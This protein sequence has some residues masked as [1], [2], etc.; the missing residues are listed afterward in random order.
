LP[1]QTPPAPARIVNQ[2]PFERALP[3]VATT[4]AHNEIL[5]ADTAWLHA[6]TR[7]MVAD[8]D[9]A[10]DVAQ[11]TLL[12]ACRQRLAIRHLRPWLASVAANFARRFARGERRRRRHEQAVPPREP[13]PPTDEV[14]ARAGMHRDVV[15]AVLRLGEPYRATLL[16]RFQEQQSCEQIA[17]RMRVPVET[18]R[19]RVK[20]GL[21]LLR[22]AMDAR[23]GDRRAWALPI[24][25]RA[26]FDLAA[27]GSAPAA[28]GALALL[29]TAAAAAGL[30]A[31]SAWPPPPAV[32]PPARATAAGLPELASPADAVGP[33]A[34]GS[35]AE[36][37]AVTTPFTD[38]FTHV[39]AIADERDHCVARGRVVDAA[40]R[41]PLAGVRVGLGTSPV[42]TTPA[43]GEPEPPAPAATVT[44]ADGA[45]ELDVGNAWPTEIALRCAA[46]A[47]LRVPLGFQVAQGILLTRRD[48]EHPGRQVC[49]LGEIPL[50]LGL[51][52][53]GRV[54]TT[55][56]DRPVPGAAIEIVR[57]EERTLLRVEA[58]GESDGSG[59]FAVPPQLAP[60]ALATVLVARA[61]SEVGWRELEP[62]ALTK[63]QPIEVRLAAR[64][65]L[66]VHIVDEL[67]QPL[68]SAHVYLCP[69]S[70][71]LGTPDVAIVARGQDV[72]PVNAERPWAVSDADGEALFASL[73]V[74]AGVNCRGSLQTGGAY[75]LTA[76]CTQHRGD[77]VELLL[78]A[79]ANEARVVLPRVDRAIVR[80]T[81][82]DAR[83][84]RPI[85]GAR[86]AISGAGSM[87]TTD[88]AGRYASEP[89]GLSAGTFGGAA[90]AEGYAEQ[91]RSGC[92]HG[93]TGDL[94]L[95]FALAVGVTVTVV[96]D[97]ERPVQDFSVWIDDRQRSATPHP[98]VLP[99]GQPVHVRIVPREPGLLPVQI[100]AAALPPTP[101]RIVLPGTRAGTVDLDLDLLDAERGG[102]VALRRAG[103]TPLADA[104]AAVAV[105][106]AL[107]ASRIG[108]CASV[109]AV[110]A[111]R[112]ELLG[113]SPDERSWRGI[114]EVPAGDGPRRLAVALRP[115]P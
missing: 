71:P 80:G 21:A 41:L 59:A 20:R 68:P 99:A 78:H 22:A 70:L 52:L 5:L 25:G 111:G 102:A 84:G 4:E 79:G 15:D 95:D 109:R 17:A 114:V 110:P 11:E 60:S 87:P 73:P 38:V 43:P 88:D 35:A 91:W 3:D 94:Q 62:D 51:S 53:R 26:A 19:T 49:D 82:V 28:F 56:G 30:F 24:L 97:M 27:A 63:G 36:R 85:P 12:A 83:T 76:C 105:G 115:G 58:L 81:V 69:T 44:D 75:Q 54:L 18:V 77:Q 74:G 9:L 7:S 23:H 6:L 34:T 101:L 16:L 45:F 29:G 57:L 67:D 33:L 90:T 103:L 31:W 113:W 106:R 64:A 47:V 61:G 66:R 32:A 93:A 42:S 92:V 2:T 65:D 98:L 37:T 107:Q 48:P 100:D 112:Y 55:A 10:A 50:P 46:Q 86:V 104:G 8:A 40:R 96:D 108:A 1:A 89:V 13:A 14:V 39:A 72:R